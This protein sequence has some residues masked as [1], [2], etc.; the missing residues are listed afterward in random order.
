MDN[1]NL[2]VE[3]DDHQ[4]QTWYVYVHVFMKMFD[5]DDVSDDDDDDDEYCVLL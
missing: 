2:F 4:G 1:S 3:L 5:G